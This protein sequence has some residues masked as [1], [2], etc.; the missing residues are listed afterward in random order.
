MTSNF[1]DEFQRRL[2]LARTGGGILFC[3]AGF[4]ADCLNFSP[5]ETIG[6]GAHLLELFNTELDQNP[7]FRNLQNA[8]DALHEKIADYGMMNLLKKRFTVSNVT[9]DMAE[10]LKYP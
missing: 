5:D 2:N 3:G 8:A 10:I 7:P 9:S 4:S 1:P 6:A